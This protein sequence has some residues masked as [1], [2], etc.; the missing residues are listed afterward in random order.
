MIFLAIPWMTW[1]SRMCGGGPP[2]LSWGLDQW[3]LPLPYLLFF[4]YISWWV[5]PAYLGA[6]LAL[7]SGH[8][9][10]FDYHL[11]FKVGSEPEKIEWIIPKS[12]PV[13]IQKIL[14]MAL[15]GLCVTILTTLA[16]A[17]HGLW[18]AAFLLAISGILKAIAYFLPKT[19]WAE[20]ARGFFLGCGFV[21]AMMVI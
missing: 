15:T 8:G 3:L 21:A 17:L 7:R 5:I 6:V 14:I 12:L 1:L 2:K 9:R 16:L 18:L 20:L 4:P 11:P 19:E 10:G 13:K